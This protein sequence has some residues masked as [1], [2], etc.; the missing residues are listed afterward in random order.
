MMAGVIEDFKPEVIIVDKLYIFD[1]NLFS[2]NDMT[3]EE[4]KQHAETAADRIIKKMNL[5]T[6]IS[7]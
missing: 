1:R 5:N 3:E 7:Y 2:I 6:Q 4:I